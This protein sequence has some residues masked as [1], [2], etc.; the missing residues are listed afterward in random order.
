MTGLSSVLKSEYVSGVLAQTRGHLQ[1]TCPA[2]NLFSVAGAAAATH[3][4]QGVY[5]FA[6][7]TSNDINISGRRS[8]TLLGQSVPGRVSLVHPRLI[9]PRASLR[10]LMFF[11]ICAL[12]TAR[13]GG[14]DT[15]SI[16]KIQI[17]SWKIRGEDEV[18]WPTFPYYK[19][20]G[21]GSVLLS[22]FIFVYLFVKSS[23]SR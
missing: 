1:T 20:D 16:L 23:I 12:R 18:R 21:A 8:A 15:F 3:A 2:S 7:I 10:P 13:H 19:L 11:C 4:S 22:S 9:Y 6:R 17:M 5:R 14:G